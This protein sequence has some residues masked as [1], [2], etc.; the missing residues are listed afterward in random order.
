MNK[1]LQLQQSDSIFREMFSF[2]H[3]TD[4]LNKNEFHSIHGDIIDTLNAKINF[5]S[6]DN[7]LDLDPKQLEAITTPHT[8]VRYVSSEH[9][10]IFEMQ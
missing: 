7:V 6:N 5:D 2:I 9:L 1:L 3:G 4:H 8:I 10:R